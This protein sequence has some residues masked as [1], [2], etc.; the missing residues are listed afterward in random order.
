[1]VLTNKDY[2]A[3]KEQYES[4]LDVCHKSAKRKKPTDHS[5]H[6]LRT[7]S[8]TMTQNIQ[9]HVIKRTAISAHV[10][11]R[12]RR[13]NLAGDDL[14]ALLVRTARQKDRTPKDFMGSLAFDDLQEDD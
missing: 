3:H 1:M 7:H 4:Y 10:L 13:F 12:T 8:L 9:K 6:H 14:E 11:N 5:P 2:K